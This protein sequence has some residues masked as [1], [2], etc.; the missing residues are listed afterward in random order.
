MDQNLAILI[1][2]IPNEAWQRIWKLPD[3]ISIPDWI[4]KNVKL[5][6]KTSAEP[7]A[8]RI[9]RTPYTR[10]PLVALGDLFIEEVIL[11]WGRQLGKTMGVLCPFV[12]YVIAQ[13][14]GPGTFLL[15]TRDKAKEYFETKLDPVF[16]ACEEIRDRMPD[17]PDD[18]TKLRMNFST[19]V[20]AMAWA[21]SESQTTTRSNRYLIVDEADEIKKAVGEH[22]ID[23]IRGIEQTLTT[24]SNRKEIM[25]SSPTIPEGN[26]W[27]A[28]KKCQ[29][30]FE[31]WIPCPH[32]R[33]LQ[34]LYWENVRFGEDHDPVVVEEIAWYECEACQGKIPNMDKIRMLAKGEWR[35]RLTADPCDQIM[36]KVRVRIEDTISLDQ[37][38]EDMRVKRIGFFLPK[39]YSPFSGG[40]F[41]VIAKEFIEANKK[42]Q[43]GQDFAPMRNWRIYNAARPWEEETIKETELELMANRIDVPSLICPKETLAITCGIDRSEKGFWYVV[44][45]WVFQPGTNGYASHLLHYGVMAEDW[46]QLENFVLNTT[47]AVDGS[48]T[49]RK[50]ILITGFD[51]GGGEEQESAITQTAEGYDWLR[52]MRAP[53]KNLRIFGTKGLSR[54]AKKKVRQGKIDKMPGPKGE[55]IAGGLW[56]WEMDTSE[57]KKDMWF[58]L[59]RQPDQ[60]G[61]FTFH[62][63]TDL[64]YMRHLL[65]EKYLIEGGNWTWKRKGRNHWLDATIIN[66]ALMDNECYGL[67][68][69]TLTKKAAERRQISKG[70]G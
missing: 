6:E 25:A 35:A 13:D 42:L 23:P 55:P 21:G 1:K 58:H 5:S 10:G 26:I 68:I 62:S 61:R 18:Y 32:C 11:V 36:K 65:S 15:P 4:E 70:I 31:Y 63:E 30:V 39:W 38:L 17:N 24:Y 9:E 48:E 45:A 43:E 37:V 57:L 51:T 41:G 64:D 19:M 12:C 49:L 59:R 27:Q 33:R 28:L 54:P 40:T 46:E 52:K 60:T 3:D 22:A 7:G 56:I 16:Q 2:Q 47:Y 66:F 29:Y 67:Q 34:I 20:L 14:P 69:M 53:D 44:T 8:L 50:P